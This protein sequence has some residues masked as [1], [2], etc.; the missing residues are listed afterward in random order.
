MIDFVAYRVTFLK[1]I[2][3]F[4]LSSSDN[5][6]YSQITIRKNKYYI[7]VFIYIILYLMYY[8]IILITW[9]LF[10]MFYY[11]INLI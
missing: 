1:Q 7:K 9:H 11:F 8:C 3:T 6:L 2:V 5:Q 4:H 10:N